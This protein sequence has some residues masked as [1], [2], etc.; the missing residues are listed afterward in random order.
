MS[1]VCDIASSSTASPLY[2]FPS[3]ILSCSILSVLSFGRFFLFL[4]TRVHARKDLFIL[5]PHEIGKYTT[6]GAWHRALP[7][8]TPIKYLNIC[9][10]SIYHLDTEVF[11]S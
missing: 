6:S 10:I 2:T 4:F 9:Y 5:S 7:A 8:G 1:I 11:F 3:Y